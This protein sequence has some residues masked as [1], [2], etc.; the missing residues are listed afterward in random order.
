MKV[1]HGGDM[2]YQELIENNT[3]DTVRRIMQKYFEINSY[4]I[5]NDGTINCTGGCMLKNQTAGGGNITHLPIKFGVVGGG[6]FCGHN[7]LESLGGS[8]KRVGKNFLCDYNNLTSLSGAPEHVGGKF[9]CRANPLISLTGG[10]KYVGGDYDANTDTLVSLE[11]FPT[12]LDG[13]FHCYYNPHLPLLRTLIAKNGVS[14]LGTNG[15]SVPKEHPV[16]HII[17]QFKGHTNLRHA[18]LDCQK[19]L[20]EAGF[21]GNAKW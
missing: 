1:M 7:D 16:A 6:F 13:I 3:T 21:E 17:N 12:E 19:A 15:L 8:P 20:R 5:T 4:T 2:K 18:I 11:G 9:V 10:P 14:I